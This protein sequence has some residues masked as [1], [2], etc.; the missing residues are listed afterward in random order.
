M[1]H[2]CLKVCFFG[3]GDEKEKKNL[4]TLVN[5]DSEHDFRFTFYVIEGIHIDDWRKYK[6]LNFDWEYNKKSKTFLHAIV[7][8]ICYINYTKNIE[9]LEGKSVSKLEEIQ[10][11]SDENDTNGLRTK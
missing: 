3:K 10:W 9:L 5:S 8:N 4:M 1:Y 11:V 2:H 7:H 6:I